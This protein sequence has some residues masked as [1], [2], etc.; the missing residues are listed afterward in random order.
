MGKR[1]PDREQHIALARTR[2]RKEGANVAA[3]TRNAEID[4]ER[5][6]KAQRKKERKT[7][8]LEDLLTEPSVESHYHHLEHRDLIEVLLR[9]INYDDRIAIV[10][11]FLEGY[12][13]QEIA[14][15]MGVIPARV[16]QR[17]VK[18]ITRMQ[19]TLRR[20]GRSGKIAGSIK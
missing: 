10:M 3:S 14:E 4:Y 11:H 20:P 8:R 7:R 9:S 12:K 2:A 5:T 6:M 17:I 16:H 1:D 19:E 18:G 13:Q 15:V